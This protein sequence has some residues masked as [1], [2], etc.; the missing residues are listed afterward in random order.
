MQVYGMCVKG[1]SYN[2]KMTTWSQDGYGVWH[3]LDTE[4][5]IR[6]FSDI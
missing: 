2:S 3:V 4:A 6:Q 5:H 1:F